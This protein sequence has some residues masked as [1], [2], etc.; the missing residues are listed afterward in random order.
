MIVNEVA[1]IGG[2]DS[3]TKRDDVMRL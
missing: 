2:H 3:V 1:T